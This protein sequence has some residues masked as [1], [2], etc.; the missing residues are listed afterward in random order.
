MLTG[1]GAKSQQKI[2]WTV[3]SQRLPVTYAKEED[4]NSLGSHV[5][6]RHVSSCWFS[7]KFS[8]VS[9][10]PKAPGFVGDGHVVTG[11]RASRTPKVAKM[12]C[13]CVSRPSQLS[14]KTDCNLMKCRVKQSLIATA[15]VCIMWFTLQL[16]SAK[17]K[18]H[19]IMTCHNSANYKYLSKTMTWSSLHSFCVLDFLQSSETSEQRALFLLGFICC[20]VRD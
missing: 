12:S 5:A 13:A 10:S 9:H 14:N 16:V 18:M 8:P 2:L 20:L 11:D 3:L 17:I 7:R 1:F 19:N 15:V 4:T 6:W